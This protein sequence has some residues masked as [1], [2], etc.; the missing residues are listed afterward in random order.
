VIERLAFAGFEGL[1]GL[2][3][4]AHL[5]A[6]TADHHGRLAHDDALAERDV[7]A[8]LVVR[9]VLLQLGADLDVVVAPGLEAAPDLVLA[10]G[11]QAPQLGRRQVPVQ[12]F[13]QF[14]VVAG[15]AGELAF[16]ARDLDG[17][18]GRCRHARG[19]REQDEEGQARG[20]RA[21]T[22]HAAIVGGERHARESEV[23]RSGTR[24]VPEA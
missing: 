8:R 11:R 15:D 5:A 13:G 18:R 2:A 7:V 14:Q 9:A 24:P 6:R 21:G 22:R 23:G 3:H 12:V 16:D 17:H 10:L 4:H 20:G 19:A 1:D